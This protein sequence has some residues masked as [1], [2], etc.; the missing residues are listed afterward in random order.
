MQHPNLL[1]Q[2][3]KRR[4]VLYADEAAVA[5]SGGLQFS[6][7]GAAPELGGGDYL[8]PDDL[9]VLLDSFDYE[10]AVQGFD[11][12]GFRQDAPQ[13][14]RQQ[15]VMQQGQAVE[16]QQ[17]QQQ[18]EDAHSHEQSGSGATELQSA[19]SGYDNPAGIMPVND[20]SLRCIDDAHP[21]DCTRCARLGLR[22]LPAQR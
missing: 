17:Q 10:G 18:H 5:D 13:Q 8:L 21:P 6:G 14:Y 20:L 15:Q 22:G 19:E 2:Q 16:H 11:V 12:T 3:R 9:D 4:A 1:Q 7:W